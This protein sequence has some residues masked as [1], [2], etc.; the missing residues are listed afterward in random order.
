MKSRARGHL[1]AVACFGAAL[2]SARPAIAVPASPTDV[3]R[4]IV[5]ASASL[6]RP[7]DAAVRDLYGGRQMGLGLDCEIRVGPAVELFVGG[8]FASARG[9]TA[10]VPPQAFDESYEIE[11]TNRSLQIGAALTRPG[12]ARLRWMFGAGIA[13]GSY[14]ERWP[15]LGAPVQGS[16]L[17]IVG[18][19]G[20][21]Y[22]LTSSLGVVARMEWSLLKARQAA[23]DGTKPNLGGVGLSLGASARF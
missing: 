13:I 23:D 2:G 22:A 4:I 7:G 10:V 1:A 14:E 21:H 17:G 6:M 8:R 9:T 19:G 15:V 12:R 3:P 16:S 5:S 20:A 18:L 11:L